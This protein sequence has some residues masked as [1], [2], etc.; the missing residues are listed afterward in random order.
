MNKDY[1]YYYTLPEEQYEEELK[2]WF[3]T[4][5]GERLDLE[6]PKT[7]NEKI[8]WMKL[9]DSTEIKAL[10]ADKYR[11]RDWVEEKIGKEY[12]VPLL[13][14]WDS[15]DEIDFDTLPDQFVLKAN[16][17]SGYNYIVS[18]KNRFNKEE[19]R[20]KF[21]WWMRE[22]FA[23][24][25]GL[26][27]HYQLIKR[28]IIAEKYIQNAG[29]DLYDYKVFCFNG[30]AE[31]IMFLSNRKEK[32]K[33]VFYDLEWNRLPYAYDHQ[34]NEEEIPKPENLELLI[35]LSEKLAEGFPH[36]RVDFY[37]L[38]DGT[39]LFGEM[40]FPSAGGRGI[41][42]T[43]EPNLK[44][45]KLISLPPRRLLPERSPIVSAIL[46][47]YFSGQQLRETLDSL[48]AQ[49]L[50]GIEILCADDDTDESISAVLT[51]YAKEDSRLRI[52]RLKEM[53]PA[54]VRNAALDEA[55]GEFV[56]F[57]SADGE[58]EPNLLMNACRR[59]VD[60]RADIVLCDGTY[61]RREENG[62]K[63]EWALISLPGE[64]R[65][66]LFSCDC[67]SPASMG[68]CSATLHNKMFRRSFLEKKKLRFKGTQKNDDYGFV[69]AAVA[70]CERIT[71]TREKILFLNEEEGDPTAFIRDVK[72]LS[73]SENE[74]RGKRL[75]L[76]VCFA[77]L[78]K[79]G[80]ARY[81]KLYQELKESGWKRLGL[82]D[83]EEA[84]LGNLAYVRQMK[85]MLNSDVLIRFD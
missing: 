12:L 80:G 60:Q 73:E 75:A 18:D 79:A 85:A 62:E 27:L 23:F 67:I 46:T 5:T 74:N 61:I 19:A 29:N 3:R 33:M 49:S 8:Q 25:N 20:T 28:K 32:L 2:L 55:Q 72:M 84:Q 38:D 7:Y 14:V 31:S 43:E 40:T 50:H 66:G 76:E 48:L 35:Q 54:S 78:K 77:E 47:S 51:A 11:V 37:R 81:Q 42:N 16:H 15:F 70:A 1:S 58:I 56:M 22:E 21:E 44:Y 17:G 26:E 82:A 4:K 34:I 24:R 52:V 65:K 68:I 64:L 63:S 83:A 57:L 6:S 69:L 53:D 13:G 9:Y 45:G 10:L 41:W 71:V 30:K 59:I 39:Y 36:V